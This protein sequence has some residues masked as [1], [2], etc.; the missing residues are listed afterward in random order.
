MTDTKNLLPCPMC[1][2]SN[3]TV[4]N[5][6]PADNSGGYFIEC[7]ECGISTNLCYACGDDPIP[8][9]AELWNHRVSTQCLHQIAEPAA[10]PFMHGIADGCGNAY[11][12]EGC[13]APEAKDLQ[14]EV[15]GLNSCLGEDESP[16]RVVAL[17]AHPEQLSAEQTTKVIKA[18]GMLEN[19]ALNVAENAI[20]RGDDYDVGYAQAMAKM[21]RD[22]LNVLSAPAH[23]AEGVPSQAV[24]GNDLIRAAKQAL[25]CMDGLQQHLG[26]AV[27]QIEADE[28]RTAL[29]ATQPAAQGMDAQQYRLLDHGE[30]IEAGDEFLRDD[31][32]WQID[33]KGL[34]VG[35]PLGR[36][37]RPARRAIA[38][39]AKQGGA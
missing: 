15:D 6:Q 33:P 36:A 12:E 26:R 37:L 38:A 34:F 28:L 35:C 14:P 23:P 4:K 30:L 10:A 17:Y 29:A 22:T 13:V 32:T 3:I 9:L 27:C 16:Y 24:A 19:G 20:N 11:F 31:F 2:C 21:A 8:L 18:L 25:A 7:P 1:G 39:Q 5:E